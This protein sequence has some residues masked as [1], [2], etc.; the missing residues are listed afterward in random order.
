[1]SKSYKIPKELV[2][3]AYK[4][5][6]ANAG[7]AG[8]DKQSL[9]DFGKNLENNL[10][11]IWNRMSSGSYFPPPVKSVVIPK[12]TGGERMLGIPTVSD[13]IAQMVVKL[14]IEPKVE[15][16]FLMDSY[17]YRPNKSALQ[18]IEVTRQR[19]WQ[20]DW[21][22]EYDIKNLFDNIP[23]D[24]LMKAVRKHT[25]SKWEILYIERWLKAPMQDT[26]GQTIE[27]KSGTPQGGVI[28]PIL[29]NLYLHYTFD[30]W[31]QR[32]YPT[33]KWCRYADDGLIHCKSKQEAEKLLKAIKERFAKC[34]L[35]LHPEKTRI[36]HCK[37]GRRKQEHENTSFDFLG[38][39][40]R[41]RWCCNRNTKE[42]FLG[43][44]PAVSR[45]AQKAMRLKIRQLR[46]RNR[47]GL[48]LEMIAKIMNPILL[49]WI[50]YYSKYNKTEFRKV[51]KYVNRRLVLWAMSKYKRLSKKRR[52]A[53]NFLCEICNNSPNLF[54]HWQRSME[55]V[56]V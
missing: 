23:H 3:K 25:E 18:A 24:P 32:K 6:K 56:I 5:V 31:M 42:M 51:S 26:K 36:V 17:G 39:T 28:S 52:K 41:T 16:Y 38:Y 12:K 13:R 29:S 1:V 46:L 45:R 48:S 44:S 54:I 2:V 11:K 30:K 49:G 34:G 33:I 37:D 15:P 19:C 20:Y 43:F 4:C 35:E 14:E 22:V 10:Y 40:F 8:I 47:T 55:C 9:E 27:R 50:N 7:S 21:V 53:L